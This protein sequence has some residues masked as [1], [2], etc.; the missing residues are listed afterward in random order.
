MANMS[1]C[2]WENTAKDMQD[3]ANSLHEVDDI[4]EWFA[5]LDDYEQ[6]GV[7]GVLRN[8]AL[9]LEGLEELTD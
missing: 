4:A 6:A 5:G 7:R 8:A 3:C 9:L 2:R 1:Y